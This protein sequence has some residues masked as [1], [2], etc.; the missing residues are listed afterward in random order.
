[1]IYYLTSIFAQLFCILVCSEFILNIS[2]AAQIVVA[3]VGDVNS[4][5][6]SGKVRIPTNRVRTTNVVRTRINYISELSRTSFKQGLS[7]AK[8]L[9]K[10]NNNFVYD[11][12]INY[13]I[14]KMR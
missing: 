10:P 9:L 4:T 6:F 5:F 12:L 1:M 2:E 8:V 11:K 14:R 7:S 13:V 3:L